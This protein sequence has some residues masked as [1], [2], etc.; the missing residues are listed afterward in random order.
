MEKSFNPSEKFLDQ[1]TKTLS[2]KNTIIICITLLFV[3][4]NYLGSTAEAALMGI[5]SIYP[6]SIWIRRNKINLTA[7]VTGFVIF[8]LVLFS[9]I[10]H[11]PAIAY[12][13]LSE[14]KIVVL[15]TLPAYF[16]FLMKGL[17]HRE[18]IINFYKLFSLMVLSV[19]IYGYV[20]LGELRYTGILDFSI[21]LSVSLVLFMSYLYR[22]LSWKWLSITLLNVIMLGS[23]NGLL[24]YIIVFVLKSGKPLWSKI[25]PSVTSLFYLYWYITDFR[26]RE[27]ADGAFW[28]VDRVLLITSLNRYTI[29]EFNLFNYLFGYGIGRPLENFQI[30]SRVS[31]DQINGFIN[32]FNDFSYNGV[33]P[34]SF[35]NEFSRIFY[36]F[37]LIGLVLI[38]YY[39]YKYLDKTTF[40]VLIVACIT[41]TIIYSTVGLF[42]LSLMIAVTMLD[43]EKIKGTSRA[44]AIDDYS[45]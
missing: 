33:Y 25:I 35:H 4:L 9:V 23:S 29:R 13:F 18:I 7:A 10:L 43:K 11:T 37:G 22:E 30:V 12:Y 14:L 3:I 34:F 36:N 17:D 21:Y 24:I 26:G 1:Q 27:I 44:V 39:L 20:I 41:N 6:I 16:Y 31:N 2:K 40:F 8:F 19:S 38:Y 45:L 15:L 42:I 32:W 5:V 28:E